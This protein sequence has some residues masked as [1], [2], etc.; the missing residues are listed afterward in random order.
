MNVKMILR[1]AGLTVMLLSSAAIFAQAYKCASA[2]VSERAACERN[3]N[4]EA[5]CSSLTGGELTKCSFDVKQGYCADDRNPE[6]CAALVTLHGKCRP[7]A[8]EDY[9]VCM[10]STKL[11]DR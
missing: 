7:L 10:R 11:L 5:K 3:A 9:A 4:Y 2:P 6:R 1:A 8:G